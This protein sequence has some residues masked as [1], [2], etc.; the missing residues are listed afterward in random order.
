[1]QA[2]R[3]RRSRHR[4]PGE[5]RRRHF[6]V[7]R[8]SADRRKAAGMGRQLRPDDLRRRR[9]DGRSGPRRARL[10]VRQQ[11]R[12]ADQAGDRQGRRRQRLRR[13]RLAGVVRREGRERPHRQ[14]RQVR[15]PR[16]PGRLRRHRRRP[17]GQGPRPGAH[18]VPPARLGHQPPALLGLP[19]PDHPLPVLRRR[20]G[21]GRPAAGH[22]AGERGAGRRRFATG[23]HA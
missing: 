17:A 8:A 1:M 15:Q 14:L 4:Y 9:G 18:P 3:R 20:T 7:R 22:P 21:A 16:L 10:R 11:V 19:D 13:Q 6:P 12:P 5:E 2:R 23:A